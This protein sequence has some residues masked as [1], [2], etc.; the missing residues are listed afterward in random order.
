MKDLFGS[1]TSALV[2][3]TSILFLC[4]V[5]CVLGQLQRISLS[6]LALEVNLSDPRISPNGLSVYFG[7]AVDWSPDG[8]MLA[9]ATQRKPHSGDALNRS[10]EAPR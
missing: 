4:A 10:I 2:I 8:K 7:S 9:L 5:T 6:D 3:K 1:R